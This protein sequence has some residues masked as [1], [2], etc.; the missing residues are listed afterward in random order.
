M[1]QKTH[2]FLFFIFYQISFAQTTLIKA[3]KFYNS[4][5]NKFEKNIEILISGKI[6]TQVGKNLKIPA[7]TKII[8]FSNCTITPGLI[9]AHTHFLFKQSS[10][11]TSIID[12]R[13]NNSD[14]ERSIRA[15]KICKDYL[16]S[17]ITTVR[18]IGNSGEYIDVSLRNAINK[19]YFQG[20]TMFVS[21]KIISSPGG[22][23]DDLPA[24]L[25]PII[26]KEYS[27]IKNSSEAKAAV[28]EH[29]DKKVDFIKIC[30]DNAPG[31]LF[32]SLGEI[33][34]IVEAAHFY[35]LQVT[36]HAMYEKSVKLAVLSGVDGIEHGY[37]ISD[38]ILNIMGQ[39]N[40]YLVPNDMALSEIKPLSEFAKAEFNARKDRFI[41]AVNK[42]I[43][44]VFGSDITLNNYD[45]FGQGDEA[46]KT[47]L[48]YFEYGI[49][50]N[51][52]LKF[53]TTNPASILNKKDELGVIKVNSF[54]DIVVF[55]GDLEI[56]FATILFKVKKV[57]KNGQIIQ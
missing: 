54:A 10:K 29:V 57:F 46:K 40:I 36:A 55:D 41:R 24:E 34:T 27:V 12:D 53:A 44:I 56:D 49:K 52:I 8:D 42:G 4:E 3:G 9:D 22:Q 33:K 20:P 37:R 21:G 7:G 15:I 18:D 50:P 5:T 23:S 30:A 17:G 45:G 31:K 19:N 47:L 25:Q 2:L 16:L 28:I 38:S 51:D 1:K 43:K 39:K 11:K 35:K 48:A 32:L 13:L 6:I 26:E 14:V